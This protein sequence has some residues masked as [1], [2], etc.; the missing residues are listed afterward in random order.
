MEEDTGNIRAVTAQSMQ[1]A[2][3]LIEMLPWIKQAY[4]KTIVIKYGGSA[5]VDPGLRKAVMQDIVMLKLV[6]LNPIIVHGG[7]KDITRL[8]ERLGLPVEFKN[9]IRVTPPEVMEVV[10]ME[11]VGKVNQELDSELNTHGQIAVGLNGADGH[12]VQAKGWSPEMGRVGVV[13]S[14]DTTLLVDLIEKD[15]IPVIASVSTSEDGTSF[16]VNADVV[17]GEVAE[18]IG[19]HKLVYLTDVDGLYRDFQDKESLIDRIK[20]G[21]L[22]QLIGTGAIATGM[23]P[24]INS[25][26]KAVKAGVGRAHVLNGT[27]EH[28]ILLELFTDLGVGTMIMP[29]DAEAMNSFDTY[30]L[31]NFASKL[32]N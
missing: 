19:A 26:I 12:I 9:G 14:V 20:V 28:S 3:L 27:I 15:Y 25:C 32:N 1:K 22:E 31:D 23:L 30:P 21:E 4:G 17:A 13:D 29:D 24:K 8:C 16:N 6:G 7:G 10:K 2:Q 18:A 5:M 11:L